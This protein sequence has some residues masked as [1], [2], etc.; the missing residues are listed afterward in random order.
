[1]Q[2]VSL[3]RVALTLFLVA[4]GASALLAIFAVLD[5]NFGPGK[6]RVLGTTAIITGASV[7]ALACAAFRERMRV[8]GDVGIGL[9]ILAAVASIA[10]VWIQPRAEE[11][12]KTTFVLVVAAT[13][14]AHGELMLLPRLGPRFTWVQSTLVCLI[15]LLAAS[16]AWVI[17]DEGFDVG[18]QRLIA[19]LSILVAGLTV[20]V[21]VLARIE[22]AELAAD[23]PVPAAARLVL[24]QAADGTWVD[25][26]GARFEVRRCGGGRGNAR[27]VDG[28]DHGG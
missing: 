22:R 7:L 14:T 16:V 19:V 10:L 15:A 21:P 3:R 5:G 24:V 1:M 12:Y 27:G 13:A 20:A 6:A 23:T 11:L 28:G 18:T 4:L 2:A 25:E 26:G 8:A 9:S 17:V